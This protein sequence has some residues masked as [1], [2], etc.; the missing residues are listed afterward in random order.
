[1][2]C[3]N[4][5]D[6]LLHDIRHAFRVF[7]RHPG[8]AL[9]IVVTLALGIGANAAIF[10][11][12]YSVLLKPLPY[13]DAEQIYGVEVVVP[14]R[15][16]QVPSLPPTIQAYREWSAAQ[17]GFSAI[18]ALTPWEC[19]VTGDGEPERLGGA[20]VSANFFTFL[21]IPIAHGRA[22]LPEE[23][24]PGHEHVVVISDALWRRRYGS[25][26]AMV[27]KPIV[28]N[29]QRHLVVGIAA[30][31]LLVPPGTL[32]HPL[33]AFA[34][35][36]DI[37]RP[38]APT[39]RELQ[40]ESWD[41]GVL[42]R[43]PGGASLESGRQQLAAVLNRMI[44]AQVP[45]VKTEL[46]IQLVPIRDVYSRG[47]RLRL[48]L[49]LAASALLLV[50][51]CASVANVLLAR[52][53]SRAGEVATRIALGA[54]RARILSHALTE[55]ILLALA[56]GAVG[57]ILATYGASLLALYGSEEVRLLAGTSVNLPFLAFATAASLVTGAVCGVVPAWQAFRG[58]AIAALQD[59]GRWGV[60]SRRGGRA[61]Q[62][63][64]GLE[65]ALA[66][67]LLASAALL[68]RS[69]VNVMNTDRGYEVERVLAV[70]LSLFGERYDAGES[71]AAFY[72]ELLE[73]V[74]ALPGVMAAGA[75]SY[76]P[77]VS[78]SEG[79][80]RTIF[81]PTDT[82]F[83]RVVLARPVAMVRSVTAGYFA[84][85]GSPLR[86]G[87][88]LTDREQTPVAVISEGLA[89]RLW[90][91]EASSAIIGRQLR[92]G[93]V[94]GSLIAVV[95]LVAD[96]RPGGLDRDAP[97]AIYRPYIQWAS[98]PMTLVIRTATEPAAQALAV[99]SEIRKTD[100]NLPVS[101]MRTMRD[102]VSST[103]AERRFQ[104]TLI[105]LFGLVALM[106]GAV[107]VYGVVSYAVASRTRDIGLRIALGAVRADVM[108]WVLASGMRPVLVGLAAGL[109]GTMLVARIF[110]SLLF[111]ITPADPLSLGTV[112]V[113]LVF[114]AGLACYLPARR[115]AGL[116]PMIALH[117][118]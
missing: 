47:A 67:L 107:G 26:P 75:I 112:V 14:E 64:I 65:M 2:K 13:H 33:L 74:R 77:A 38:I 50:T 8:F 6:A 76:L 49:V 87:R 4:A 29:E 68:L 20:R 102:L 42:V 44:R 41:H 32:L 46:A 58:Q 11:V 30:P 73:H 61:R 56:G 82:D 115:A 109:A 36:V 28:I 71:R 18:A 62:V 24:Q 69:F 83:Q 91:G 80:S 48:L 55:A 111:G 53:T 86:A 98:G 59:A 40:N 93:T 57:A 103:V 27:G 85:S 108:R 63:L 31:Q 15:R 88:F 34:P 104:M 16:D 45:E 89:R 99:R 101:S 94:T 118:D 79:A 116:D 43:L 19:N 7:G 95:G 52:V 84:A 51:A 17:T 105:A 1:M 70:D 81:H 66:T 100:P 10:S 22:F 110:R 117:H 113:I 37:W 12:V 90:P 5:Y 9:V 106:L 72:S 78:A 54:S 96:A 35:R 114:T 92:Q 60:A 21:G 3:M 97:A 25:D 23:E 39:A